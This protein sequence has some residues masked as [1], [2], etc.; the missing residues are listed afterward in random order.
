LAGLAADLRK[1]KRPRSRGDASRWVAGIR[2]LLLWGPQAQPNIKSCDPEG[3]PSAE[4]IEQALRGF[5]GA[6]KPAGDGYDWF[7]FVD[8]GQ[9]LWR[10]WKTWAPSMLM[11][12]EEHA[13][14]IH[15][16]GFWPDI[17]GLAERKAAGESIGY[18]P[19]LPVG[20]S[21]HVDH[22]ITALVNGD[23]DGARATFLRR[24]GSE[25]S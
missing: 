4:E 19:H 15:P 17:V 12:Y 6:Y 3:A 5:Y 2:A 24:V 16:E 21:G 23:S 14:E 13:T 8:D 22:A 11:L 1:K 7:R 9:A 10:L 20:W 18:P 25:Y